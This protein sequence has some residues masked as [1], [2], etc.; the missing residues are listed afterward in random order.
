MKFRIDLIDVIRKAVVAG[1]KAHSEEILHEMGQLMEAARATKNCAEVGLPY[2]V[3]VVEHATQLTQE[4]TTMIG[5][6]ADESTSPRA[7]VNR[8]DLVAALDKARE[9]LIVE[10]A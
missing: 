2:L 8:P 9:Y 3:R 5:E 4:V 1:M 6:I 10:E 7:I